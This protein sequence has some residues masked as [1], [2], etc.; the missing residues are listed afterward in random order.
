MTKKLLII[1]IIF[2]SISLPTFAASNTN[3]DKMEDSVLG[4]NFPNDKIEKRVDRLEKTVYGKQKSGSID[5]RL[6]KLAK[7]TSADVIGQ[8]I[9]PTKDTFKN[10][11]DEIVKSDGTENY[12]IINICG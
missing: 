7:D 3:L 1:F 12:P 10:E 2:M 5:A 4:T 11:N 6:A 8:E 9:A